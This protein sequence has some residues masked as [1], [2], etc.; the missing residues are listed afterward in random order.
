MT[1]SLFGKVSLGTFELAISLEFDAGVLGVEGVNGIGKTTLLRVVAGLTPLTDG[2][3][4]VDGVVYDDPSRDIFV[5]ANKRSV[6]MVFQD[7]SLLPYLS[8]LDNILF[9]HRHRGGSKAAARDEAMHILQMFGAQNWAALMPDSLS[10]GQAQR[11]CLAR[12]LIANPRI[13]LLDEPLSAIDQI[14]R[15]ELRRTIGESLAAVDGYKI[16]VSHD[17]QDI[18]ELCAA[19]YFV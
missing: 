9:A 11:V 2:M 1:L 17:K 14:S 3:L 12:A 5:P 8:V 10:G 6:G 18:A 13:V 7:H 16:I 19:S 4:I 15:S